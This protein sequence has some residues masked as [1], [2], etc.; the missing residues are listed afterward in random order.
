MWT[1]VAKHAMLQYN[2]ITINDVNIVDITTMPEPDYHPDKHLKKYCDAQE[3]VR[4]V[5]KGDVFTG[6]IRSLH[7]LIQC[8]PD[9]INCA[10]EMHDTLKEYDGPWDHRQWRTDA[11]KVLTENTITELFNGITEACGSQWPV[12][13]NT[14]RAIQ[15]IFELLPVEKLQNLFEQVKKPMIRYA[16]MS[17]QCQLFRFIESQFITLI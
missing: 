11:K 7:R 16:D 4:I 2:N 3:L 17:L 10:F 5:M 8:W 12:Q 6:F 13:K 1:I 14:S 9:L 15:S